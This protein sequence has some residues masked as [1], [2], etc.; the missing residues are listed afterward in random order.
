MGT[1]QY[2]KDAAVEL[3]VDEDGACDEC[4]VGKYS[5]AEGAKV[6]TS[7]I[8]CQP[9]K[10]AKDNQV[11]RKNETEACTG[12]L[13]GQY[14]SSTDTDLTKCIYCPTGK[15]LGAEG[16]SKCIDCIPGRFSGAV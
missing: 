15:T 7:C 3:R 2:G 6:K 14:R 10:K 13:V 9:G 8:D 12:C 16:G 4:G 1:G 5:L 11:G